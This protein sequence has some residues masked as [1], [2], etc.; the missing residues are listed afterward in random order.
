MLRPVQEHYEQD[1]L[2]RVCTLVVEV[3]T[4]WDE[5]NLNPNSGNHNH[6][7]TLP[8]LRKMDIFAILG[9]S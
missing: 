3:T 1:A 4:T 5:R 6:F 9:L 2:F 7:S 8:L